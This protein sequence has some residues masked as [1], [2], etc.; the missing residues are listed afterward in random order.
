M[1]PPRNALLLVAVALAFADSAIVVLA[2]PDLIDRFDASVGAVSWVVTSY[3]LALA[4]TALA[5]P[6]LL[7]RTEPATVVRAGAAVFAAASLGCAASG[8]LWLLVGCRTVQG[9]GG[10]L[11]LAA[12]VPVLGGD[13]R[14]TT[15]WA[16][17][18]AIGAAL[19]PAVG[20]ALTQL[21]DWR[22]IFVVQAPVAALALAA[23]RV[24]AVSAP[25]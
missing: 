18:S 25:P 9:V 21:F 24:P 16:L 15:R 13:R 6:P 5:L 19:G 14:A 8:E 3:N 7:R 11:L 1:R 4:I 20:G 23:P 10:A 17:A 22:A 12:S 2:L